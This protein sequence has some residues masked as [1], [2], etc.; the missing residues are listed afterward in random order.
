[1]IMIATESEHSRVV[2]AIQNRVTDYLAKPFER[3]A[4]TARIDGT[5]IAAV[6]GRRM[7][8]GEASNRLRDTFVYLAGP[9]PQ[10]WQRRRPASKATP[11]FG[12]RARADVAYQHPA[13][14][15]ERPQLT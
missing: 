8:C 1:M 13:H 15:L 7:G 2:E 12:G 14:L 10:R 11:R 3:D 9:S 5:V 4:L 6:S